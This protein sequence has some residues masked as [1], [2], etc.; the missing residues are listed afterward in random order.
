LGPAYFA[1]SI[2]G[3]DRSD[4]FKAIWG[5]NPRL[6]AAHAEDY[7]PFVVHDLKLF[8]RNQGFLFGG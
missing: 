5:C 6:F 8:A 1:L 3:F 7:P 2:H 4:K